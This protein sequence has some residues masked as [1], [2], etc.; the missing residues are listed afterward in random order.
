[1]RVKRRRNDE[2]HHWKRKW[3]RNKLK[4]DRKGNKKVP[5]ELCCYVLVLLVVVCV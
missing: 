4:I 5:K 1:M 2:V 3:E